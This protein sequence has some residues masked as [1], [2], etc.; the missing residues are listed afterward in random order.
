[1]SEE[2]EELGDVLLDIIKKLDQ[3]DGV[4]FETLIT[5][6][7]ARGFARSVAEEKIE[8][9]SDEGSIHEPAFGWFRLVS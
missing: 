2:S 8:S 7:A 3:G 9:L 6:A 4:D 1:M 5:N